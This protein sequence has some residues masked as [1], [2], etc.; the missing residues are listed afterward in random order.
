MFSG[1]PSR[2]TRVPWIACR[3]S[4]SGKSGGSRKGARHDTVDPDAGVA[5]PQLDRQAARQGWD[6]AL[7][8]EVGGVVQVGP[9]LGPVPQV[10]D[11]AA[12]GLPRHGQPGVL[13]TE[14]RAQAVRKLVEGTRTWPTSK[15][16]GSWWRAR[17][18]ASGAFGTLRPRSLAGTPPLA[19][20]PQGGWFPAAPGRPSW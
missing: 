9:C 8:R 3:R 12:F 14:E 7:G 4:A 11:A 5:R 2:L 18:P 1:R 16:S 13:G 17:S 6:R 19:E 15:Q 20:G 10:D